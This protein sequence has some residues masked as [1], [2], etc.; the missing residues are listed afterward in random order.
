MNK[1]E[2]IQKLK[3][4]NIPFDEKLTNKELL[5]LLPD[6]SES[7]DIIIRDPAVL[8]PVELPL[9]IQLPAN[10]SKAQVAFANILNSYAYQNTSKWA[11]KKDA[12][13]AKL[14]NLKNAPDPVEDPNVRL[15]IGRKVA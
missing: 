3:D 4:L 5:A 13:I 9:I 2:I 14:R 8:R 11:S 12:L 6:E 10:A 15:S 1:T 7:N